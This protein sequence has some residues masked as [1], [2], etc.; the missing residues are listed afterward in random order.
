MA[1]EYDL[2][3]ASDFEPSQVLG[4]LSQVPGFKE[5]TFGQLIAPGL[6]VSA[7]P[8]GD[9]GRSVIKD[10]FN[11]DPTVKL[12]F[13]VD[14]FENWEAGMNNTIRACVEILL[15]TQG[16]A[17]LLFNGEYTVLRRTGGRLILS[18]D[19]DFGLLLALLW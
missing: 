5:D 2:R 9:L 19:S 17:V 4:L 15:K 16:N 7:I 8:E 1:L 11:F 10:A 12:T 14:K 13:H 3:I 6:I 18:D